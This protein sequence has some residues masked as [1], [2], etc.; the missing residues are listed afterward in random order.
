MKTLNTI[1]EVYQAANTNYKRYIIEYPNGACDL[2]WGTLEADYNI[3]EHVTE[4]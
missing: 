2:N 4:D 3:P 1:E